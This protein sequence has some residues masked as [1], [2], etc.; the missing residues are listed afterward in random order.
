MENCVKYPISYVGLLSIYNGTEV[1]TR[2]M[3]D[4]EAIQ[5]TSV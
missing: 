3:V 4:A 1:F 5:N 2:G